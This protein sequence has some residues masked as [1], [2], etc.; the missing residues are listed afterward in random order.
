ML[1]KRFLKTWDHL[2]T[3]LL[4]EKVEPANN[5]AGRAPR[6]AVQW[7]KICRNP[8][9]IPAYPHEKFLVFMCIPIVE[10]V[11]DSQARI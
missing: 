1:P 2:L 7:R 10:L 11:A 8:W 9:V 3:L 5:R 4:H 6:L